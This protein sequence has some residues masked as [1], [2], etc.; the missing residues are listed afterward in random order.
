[1]TLL[2]KPVKQIV[3]L[4]IIYGFILKF[5]GTDSLLSRRS[6]HKKLTDYLLNLGHDNITS[7][8]LELNQTGDYINAFK[9][10]NKF[11]IGS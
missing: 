8:A 6:T 2:K 7:Q 5:N 9:E 4:N 11:I 1:M 3:D 10:S